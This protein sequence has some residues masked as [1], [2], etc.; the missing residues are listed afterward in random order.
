MF[1]IYFV[2]TLFC[3]YSLIFAIILKL[4]EAQLEMKKLQNQLTEENLKIAKLETKLEDFKAK[5]AKKL[6]D[7]NEK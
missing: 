5:S 6:A 3:F 1:I 7:V 4:K 2:F